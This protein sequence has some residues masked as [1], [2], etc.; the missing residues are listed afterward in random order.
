MHSL[1]FH[2]IYL[3]S[4]VFRGPETELCT[5]VF[6]HVVVCAKSA[7]DINCHSPADTNRACDLHKLKT[8]LVDLNRIIHM[9][10]GNWV[11]KC[12]QAQ[13]CFTW[14]F[15]LVRAKQSGLVSYWGNIHCY[16]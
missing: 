12:L 13:S 8:W 1:S 9:F 6:M 4:T 3:T 15:V 5:C 10:K 16:D 11:H 2:E 7:A 14:S